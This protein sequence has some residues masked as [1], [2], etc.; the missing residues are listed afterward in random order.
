LCLERGGKA[1]P[2][3]LNALLCPKS[4]A[5]VGASSNLD[6]ISGRP[7]KLLLRYKFD[8]S[9]YPV[10]PKY[11]SL[12]GLPCFPDVSSLPET[13]DVVLIAV[14]SSLVPEVIEQC[15]AR[16]V[17]FVVIFSSGF[18]ESGDATSQERVIELA[19]RGGVR[20]V[21]PNCQGLAN[22][23]R[24]I[25]LSFSASLDSDRP[26]K[27]PVA[28]VSQSGAFGFSSYSLAVDGGV[29]FRYVVTTGNQADL[30]VVDFGMHF[31]KD[32]EVRLLLVYLEGL[33]DGE[34]FLELLRTAKEK[35]I[36]VAVLKA[37]K[38]PS[39][40]AAAK[41]HTAAVAGDKAV[42]EAVLRQYGA[43]E[44][45]DVEDMIDL[46]IAFAAPQRPEGKRVAILTTSGGAGIIMADRCSD[47]GL[48]V[49]RFSPQIQERIAAHIPPFGS[50][51]NP[52]DMTAQV[53]NEPEGFP[54]CLD[55]ALSSGEADAVVCIISMITGSSGQAMADE[56]ERAFRRSAK[57]ILC[58][59]LIDEEHGGQFLKQLHSAGLPV[60]RSLR[61]CAFAL[62]SMVK[63]QTGRTPIRPAIEASVPFLSTL[64]E[65]LTEYDSKLLLAH[66][67]VPITREKLCLSL[68]EALSA[69]NDI[70]FPVALKVIS[71]Q[72]LHK[73]E[74]G[75]VALR[76]SDEEEV[77][78]AYGRLL[79][80]ARRFDK[81][82][83]IKGVLVQE[84][85]EGG[86]ECMIGA[87]KDPVFGPIIA[88]GLGGIYVE[89]LGDVA[90]RR[91]PVDEKEAW[92]MVRSLK[93]FPLLAGARGSAKRD[94]SALADMTRRISEL[95]YVEKD[96]KELDVNPVIVLDEGHGAV[97]V[98]ALALRGK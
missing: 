27:G 7:L 22:L 56:L 69:A 21:G 37:G 51:V 36:P 72:I 14:R 65:E 55:S 81:D 89:V 47:L 44:L 38:S 11:E 61:R 76:L 28:Y 5:V 73:T 25:P 2:Q 92:E 48:D 16:R 13:P 87:K 39:A 86:L 88:V 82:A 84:M 29:G 83:Q 19:R 15:A 46:G 32:P 17:P 78:N 75:V 41:S 94:I 49:P 70:G 8:G 52:V 95:A 71:P 80:R 40:Q 63:W 45:D 42:W 97:A 57:P 50:P 64:P 9:I 74:A 3:D 68:E 96:L 77:R 79:E 93:G 34:R 10:N 23:A 59:W 18:A 91:C 98:D 24:G 30:D 1:V 90:L 54:V 26:C 62:A 6:S 53:I 35:E 60:Y 67:G 43:I 85:V 20:I 12:H 4:V 58:S 66:Y 31:L 33:N